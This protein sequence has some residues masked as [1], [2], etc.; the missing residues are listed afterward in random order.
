MFLLVR[1]TCISIEE[2]SRASVPVISCQINQ[3]DRKSID[4]VPLRLILL[5]NLCKIYFYVSI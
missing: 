1:F 3:A 4:F 5:F 2:V